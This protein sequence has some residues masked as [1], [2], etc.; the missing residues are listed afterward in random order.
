M[1]LAD[2]VSYSIYC[3]V[4]TVLVM[5]IMLVQV[6][7]NFPTRANSYYQRLSYVKFRPVSEMQSARFLICEPLKN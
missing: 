2:Q 3:A 6:S 7:E 5:K 4:F 1:D